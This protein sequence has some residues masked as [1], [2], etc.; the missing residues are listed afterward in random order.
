M[1]RDYL[2]WCLVL[3]LAALVA[4]VVGHYLSVVAVRWLGLQGF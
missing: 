1:G 2:L 3:I 4:A